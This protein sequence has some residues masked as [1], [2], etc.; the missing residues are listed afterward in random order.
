[1]TTPQRLPFRLTVLCAAMGVAGLLAALPAAAQQAPST[2]PDEDGTQKVVITAN[3]RSEKQ[4]EVAGTV[5]V[6]DGGDLERRGSRDQEDSLKLTPGVQFNKGDIASNTITI[7]G[8]GTS[9]TNEGSGAQQGPTGQYLEDV[10]LAAPTGKGVVLDVL[11]WDLDRVEVL[12]GPQGVLFGSGSLGGAVRYLY[13]K[14]RMNTFEAS[15]KGEYAQASGGD[16]KLSLFG[17]LNAPLV[18]DTAALR[19]VL[20]DRKDPG[21]IDNLGTGT[22]DAND[23]HQ[24]GGRVLVSVKPTKG[25]VATLVASTQKSEQGDTFSVSPDPTRLEHTAPNNSTRSSQTDFYSLTVDYDLGAHTLTSITGHFKNK[26]SALIDDTELFAS[27]GLVLPQVYRPTS[28]SGDATSQ[29]LRI[30]SN[31]GGGPLSYVAGVF[32]QTSKSNGVGQQIDPSAA[33][34]IATLVDLTSSSK[35][36]ET[37]IFG[38]T[39]YTFGGGWSAGAGARWYKTTTETLQT[40]T[41]FG[42]PSNVGPLSGDDSGV[43]PKL[44]VKYRFGENLWYGL[45]SKGYRYGGVNGP[46]S[47]NPFKSDG[48]WNYETGVRL[49]PA[50]GLLVDLTAF[51]MDWKDAQFTYFE[52]VNGLP[53]SSISNVGKARSIGLEAALRYRLNSTWDVNASVA[54]IDATTQVAVVIPSG[55]PTSITAPAGSKLPGTPDWQA[56]LQA[57]ARF[58]G[59]FDTQGRFNATYTYLGDRVMFLGGNKPADGFGTLDLGLNFASGN[60][61]VAAGLANVANEKGV[62]SITGAPAGVGSFA[63]YFLQRPRTTTVSLRYDY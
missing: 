6:L 19:V 11:S 51:Y 14:P 24:T 23:V 39:E 25:L 8:I 7:R 2:K 60:W 5:S 41:T 62:L 27:V 43:T 57:N 20:F 32:Y 58:A 61:T 29:E 48:L 30:A 21:Y 4:R 44:T 47:N 3:K 53:S 1:M 9:T 40:G 50:A 33:F 37:A 34:G 16:G 15:I 49:A 12:R 36:T 55:G 17:M 54:Y 35:G 18:T 59:P 38:D 45:A 28:G 31:P 46:P 26:S 10:P 63:Q 22:K 56:A 42:A 13:N 52:V